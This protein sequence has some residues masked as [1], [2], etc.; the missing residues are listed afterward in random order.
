MSTNF[1][2]IKINPERNAF[3]VMGRNSVC[4]TKSIFKTSE[5]QI[6]VSSP[7]GFYFFYLRN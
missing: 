7:N 6:F 3:F 4:R 2:I 5:D 1:G